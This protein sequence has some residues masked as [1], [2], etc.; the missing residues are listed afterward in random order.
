VR[1]VEADHSHV[2]FLAEHLRQADIK[3]CAAFG[4]D[5]F[6]ALTSGLQSSLWALTALVDDEP[7]A[8]MGVS[9]LN[10]MEG[11]GVPWMLGTDRIYDHARDMIRNAPI[12]L[13]EMMRT[14]SRLENLV[15]TDNA[16]A[17]RFLKRVGFEFRLD[18]SNVG[19]VSFVRFHREQFGV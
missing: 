2:P 10:M 17:I 11:V 7:H 5:P 8:M 3:E 12:I 9:P 1:L 18:V 15:S 19:G 4:R 6:S 14:F 13:S 16:R